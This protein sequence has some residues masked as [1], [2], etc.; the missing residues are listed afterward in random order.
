MVAAAD[1]RGPVAPVTLDF[2]VLGLPR[3]G[4]TWLSNWLTTDRTLCLHDPFSRALPERWPRDHRRRGISCTGA[5][6][7]PKWLQHQHCPT[8]VITRDRDAC[9][10]SLRKM[11][12][13]DITDD[14]VA[15][16]DAVEAPRFTFAD[17]WNEAKAKG[18]WKYLVPGVAFDPA[19][20]R[21]LR[22]VNV[23]PQ[24]WTPDWK[25]MGEVI[26]RYQ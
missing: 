23:Q 19:R 1:D 14:M 8:V 26:K 18:L 16:L 9:T 4:T 20:Y 12:L 11:G 7:L 2:M 6:M 10:A 22:D 3:S 5:Y 17:L 25:V 24:N 21:Q 13:P 15:A